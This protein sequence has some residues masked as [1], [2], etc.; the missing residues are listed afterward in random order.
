M[1][2]SEQGAEQPANETVVLVHGLWMH[3]IVMTWLARRLRRAGFKTRSFS[4]HSLLQSPAQAADRLA[5][6]LEKLQTP[7]VHLVGH[8]LGGIV[9][10]HLLDR[11]PRL[12]PGRV[13]FIGSPVNGSR[14][15]AS[16]ARIPLLGRLFLGRSVVN[17]LLGNAPHFARQRDLGLIC[18]TR[19]FGMGRLFCRDPQA[20][21]GTVFVKETRVRGCADEIQLNETHTSLLFSQA[22]AD[23]L[24]TFLQAGHFL[25]A[26]GQTDLKQKNVNR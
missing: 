19:A 10:L 18:G 4:Y 26:A 12:K 21:D 5:V 11:Q 13:V 3:G 6:Q 8:S 20:G 15:A 14:V 17:G 24:I 23:Q 2:A 9:L 22:T 1:S 16:I 25:R 7:V